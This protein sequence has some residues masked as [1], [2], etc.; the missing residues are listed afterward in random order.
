MINQLSVSFNDSDA[1]I[2]YIST[3]ENGPFIINEITNQQN[4]S[5]QLNNIDNSKSFEN[6]HQFGNNNDS[7][8]ECN[9]L[10]NITISV[11]TYYLFSFIY[12]SFSL[13]IHRKYSIIFIRSAILRFRR[14]YCHKMMIIS[15][16]FILQF[17]TAH[18]KL[19]RC[20]IL[21]IIYLNY[22]FNS[23]NNSCRIAATIIQWIYA[24][25]YIRRSVNTLW[26]VDI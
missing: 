23:A 13:R 16:V 4:N 8:N 17:W 25:D 14:L 11:Y 6:R 10:E 24:F 21:W 15:F 18:S 5:Y 12:F 19:N 26:I 3:E 20:V 1:T 2:P 22:F 7:Y 9:Q